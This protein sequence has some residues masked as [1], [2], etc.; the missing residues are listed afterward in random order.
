MKKVDLDTG[1]HNHFIGC[2]DIDDMN[3]FTGM[4]NFFEENSKQHI[5]GLVGHGK[6]DVNTKQSIDLTISPK[7]MANDN[8]YNIFNDYFSYLKKCYLSYLEDW[9]LDKKWKVMDIGSFNIQKYNPGGHFKKWHWE[10]ETL[11]HAHRIF[12][13][14]TYLNDVEEGGS[15]DFRNFDLS[16]KPLTG[17]TLIWPAEWTHAHRGNIANEEKYIITGWLQFPFPNQTT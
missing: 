17:R 16:I 5:D 1:K 10:R 3:L 9:E 15:T 14:M 7:M 11:A 4:I 2:W 12:A 13:W 8:K 6:V